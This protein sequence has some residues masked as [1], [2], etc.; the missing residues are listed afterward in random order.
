MPNKFNVPRGCSDIVSPE[1]SK[2]QSLENLVREL[3]HIYNYSEIRTPIF[4]ET[5]LFARSMGQSSD[6]V[7]KQMLN[8]TAQTPEKDGQLKLSGLSLRPENT[9]S[10]VRSYIQQNLDQ[11]ENL[12]K[13][14]YIGPMFRGERPQKGRLRQF[15]QIGVEAIGPF[16]KSPYLDAEVIALSA[17]ILRTLG[18]KDFTIKLNSLG[19]AE[20]KE[21]FAQWLRQQLSSRLKDLDEEDQIR[22]ERNVFRVLDSKNKKTK[23]VIDSLTFESAALGQES[24]IYFEQVQNALKSL[25]VNFEL[26]SKLVRGLDY[27][28]HTVFEITSTALGS[29]DALGAGGR[30]NNLVSQLGGSDVGAVGF[31]LGIER[32]LLALPQDQE[33]VSVGPDIYVIALDEKAFFQAWEITQVLRQNSISCDICYN[34]ASVK[35]LM[36]QANKS[37]ADKVIIIGENELERAVVTIKDFKNGVQKEIS[38]KDKNYTQLLAAATERF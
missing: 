12:S 32:I 22:F 4:E 27:Y 35:S 31:A 26:D 30:Y 18:L 2:W 33:A 20:D 1:V 13:L 23:A 19:S 24:R 29:Q 25:K 38:I 7:M 9:A 17:D 6:V 10:V 5:E 16:A 28:T 11:H 21:N 15:H 8:L 3:L 14:F 36:R 37:N 34:V